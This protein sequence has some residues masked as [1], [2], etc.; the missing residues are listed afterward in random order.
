MFEELLR[1]LDRL[2]G[3]HMVSVKVPSDMDRYF[4]R[5]CPSAECTFQFKAH[6]DDWREKVCNKEMFCPFCGHSAGSDS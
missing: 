3:T 4:D 5:E 1:E 2:S 6:E